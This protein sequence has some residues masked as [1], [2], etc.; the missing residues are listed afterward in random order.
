M[1]SPKQPQTNR[2]L[3]SALAAAFDAI[4]PTNR[5]EA[6]EELRATGIDPEA[7]GQRIERLATAMLNDR[8]EPGSAV[9]SKR[10]GNARWLWAAAAAVVLCVVGWALTRDSGQTSLLQQYRA[11]MQRT[12]RLPHGRELAGGPP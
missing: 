4:G 9:P 7:V 2:D 12:E 10:A 3:A 1:A 8:A 5:A 6:E 11:R